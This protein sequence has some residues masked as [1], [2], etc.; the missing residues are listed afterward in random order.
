MRRWKRGELK[1]QPSSEFLSLYT[2]KLNAGLWNLVVL[3]IYE[4]KT[5]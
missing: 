4:E 2:Q 5:C 1:I 3:I